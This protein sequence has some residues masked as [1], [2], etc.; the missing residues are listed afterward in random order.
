MQL[1]M[2]KSKSEH[3]LRHRGTTDL[4]L[5]AEALSFCRLTDDV[6]GEAGV[7]KVSFESVMYQFVRGRTD[8]VLWRVVVAGI[9]L[10]LKLLL[11]P[12]WHVL[13]DQVPDATALNSFRFLRDLGRERVF[14][15]FFHLVS[16]LAVADLL[17][18]ALGSLKLWCIVIFINVLLSIISLITT[19]VNDSLR[20]SVDARVVWCCSQL[21]PVQ[22][23]LQ[24]FEFVQFPLLVCDLV[25]HELVHR[26]NKW[27]IAFQARLLNI[28]SFF[29]LV[30][31]GF[32]LHSCL[33]GLA[34]FPHFHI[35]GVQSAHQCFL[36]TGFYFG[37]SGQLFL[38]QF[39]CFLASLAI[40]D[41]VLESLIAQALVRG[42]LFHALVKISII[43]ADRLS[44]HIYVPILQ[45]NLWARMSVASGT[46]GRFEVVE[47]RNH[48]LDRLECQAAICA[49]FCSEGC[50][51]VN[52]LL[53][54]FQIRSAFA[55]SV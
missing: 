23:V 11:M 13:L 2:N 39:V 10:L 15:G 16:S 8:V 53:N 5:G 14:R 55:F 54:P 32:V 6:Q 20:R 49:L 48:F 44:W 35:V 36:A 3:E 50:G 52:F 34:L 43:S 41:Q 28:Q 4:D 12:P 29:Q 31:L 30:L 19:H 33:D 46:P 25:C 26:A 40:A 22:L 9:V 37:L 7:D 27:Y 51:H 18:T 38:P 17:V 47:T 21:L 45:D 24:F 42:H 1:T